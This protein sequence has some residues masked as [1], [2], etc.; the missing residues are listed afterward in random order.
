MPQYSVGVAAKG[1]P[2]DGW[3]GEAD[4]AEDAA[5]KALA[6]TDDVYDTVTFVNR[7]S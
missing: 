3:V 4:N 5:A 7:I 1:Q 6:G 2:H